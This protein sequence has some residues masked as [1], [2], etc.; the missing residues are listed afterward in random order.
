MTGV[1]GDFAKEERAPP[2][3]ESYT[4]RPIGR[5]EVSVI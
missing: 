4:N 3:S 1:M 2:R 5:D